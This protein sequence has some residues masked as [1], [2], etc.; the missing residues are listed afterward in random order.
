MKWQ[1]ALPR[2]TGWADAPAPTTLTIALWRKPTRSRAKRAS[3][4]P[5]RFAIFSRRERDALRSAV[6]AAP[7]KGDAA[8]EERSTLLTLAAL[9]LVALIV[10][11]LFIGAEGFKNDVSTFEAWALTITERPLSQFFAK[12]GFADY[13]PGYLYFLLVVG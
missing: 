2:S 6:D 9:L 12:A 5:V 11:L 8:S 10:R 7:T 3:I 13:P 4:G 1:R